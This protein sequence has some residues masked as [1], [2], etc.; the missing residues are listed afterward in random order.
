MID[1]RTGATLS[2]RVYDE[3]VNAFNL[4]S[5]PSPW[6]KLANPTQGTNGFAYSLFLNEFDGEIVIAYRGTDAVMGW[7]GITDAALFLGFAT[8]QA[9]QAA[10][11]YVRVLSDYGSDTKVTFTGH[12]LGGGLASMMAVW[13]DRPAIVFDSAPSEAA[14]TRRDVIEWVKRGLGAPIPTALDAFNPAT[15][16]VKRESQI[17][18]HYA[19]GEF[20]KELTLRSATTGLYALPEVP[21]AFGDQRVSMFTMHSQALLTAGLLTPAFATAASRVQAALPLIMSAQYYSPDTDGLGTRNFLLDLIRS[22]QASPGNGKLTHFAADLNKLGNNLAGLSAAAQDA[23]VAQAIEWYYWQ[24][25]NYSGQ[26]FIQAAGGLLQYATATASGLTGAEDRA[27]VYVKSWLDEASEA[28]GTAGIGTRYDEW[29]LAVTMRW[30]S[31]SRLR[32]E[33]VSR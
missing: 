1:N 32:S 9:L 10:K 19:T 27:T 25:K 13:F 8:S 30:R 3:D 6:V 17:T 31:Q 28:H 11:V 33:G 12:S 22:E 23:L 5:V 15:D 16:L 4:P 7:D 14:A 29:N 18:N 2:L 26:Q 21:L 24:G 20:L